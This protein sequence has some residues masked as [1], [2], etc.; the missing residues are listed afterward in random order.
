VLCVFAGDVADTAAAVS[1]AFQLLSERFWRV[2]WVPG[3]H[4]LWLRGNTRDRAT[5]PDSWA[6]LMALRQVRSIFEFIRACDTRE[7]KSDKP[8]RELQQVRLGVQN[9]RWH[10]RVLGCLVGRSSGYKVTHRTELHI[11]VPGQS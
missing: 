4:E 6:K 9:S 2:V 5:Y 7:R 10:R 8:D 3:N 1:V 11:P